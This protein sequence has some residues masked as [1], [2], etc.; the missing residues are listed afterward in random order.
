[1]NEIAHFPV[2]ASV[3]I[4]PKEAMDYKEQSK[5]HELITKIRIIRYV[6]KEHMP[7]VDVAKSF[8]CHRNTIHNILYAFDHLVPQED[9]AVLLRSGPQLSQEELV[10]KYQLLLNQKRI[11]KTHKRSA[12]AKAEKAIVTLFTKKNIK[13]GVVQMKLTLTRRFGANVGLAKLSIGQLKG[14]YKRNKLQTAVTRSANGERR[15]L[16]D[17][18]A[19][20]CFSFMHLDVKH[21]LDK[22]A[23]PQDIYDLLNNNGAPI[24]E[25][26]LI[27]AKSRTRFTAYSYGLSSEFGFRFLLFAIQY[28]RATIRNQ[29]QHIRVGMDN[30]AE[31]CFGSKAKE[32][33]WNRILSV[34]N[35]SVYQYDPH[36]DIRK[37]LIERS[38]KTDD[39]ALYI[40]RGMYM[41]NT[42]TFHD[43]VIAYADY[44]N[45]QRP[46]TGH[47]MHNRTPEEVL[48]Q[49]GLLGVDRLLQFPV[50]ILE[51]AIMQL[52][53]CTSV[54]EF[55]AYAIQNPE[56]IQKSQTC[57]K[58]RRVIE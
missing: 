19:I 7:I 18:E 38:H 2:S 37:N 16:Y 25:W 34:L 26:N 55:E 49:Q 54:I 57:Q 39:E 29:E 52:R 32:D 28:I 6:K 53:K 50:L 30:G 3:V 17:Y 58:T 10:E 43:E 14:I 12:S 20:A 42:Y 23:L 40:P 41:T 22:H 48:K 51:D 31:F 27:D 4:L 45:K 5:Q 35:A 15:H 21:I 56:R 24:Y 47:G 36:F 13:V 9:Q 46:H 44:W 33:E 8:V 1:M 11:P